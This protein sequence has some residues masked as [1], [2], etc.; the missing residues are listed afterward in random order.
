MRRSHCGLHVMHQFCGCSQRGQRTVVTWVDSFDGETILYYQLDNKSFVAT[1]PHAQS[2]V[3]DRNANLKF[4]ESVPQLVS[5]LCDRIKRL[6]LL[7][8]VTQER[9]A[10]SNTR[11]YTQRKLGQDY[12]V[13]WARGFFPRDVN[14]SWVRN[15][16]VVEMGQET[17]DVVPESDGT[18]QVRSVRPLNEDGG[19]YVCQVEHEAVNGKLFIP[20]ERKREVLNEGLIIIG[21]VLAILGICSA[22]VTTVVYY[23][24]LHGGKKS[25]IHPTGSQGSVT[26]SGGGQWEPG[27]SPR[28]GGTWRLTGDTTNNDQWCRRSSLKGGTWVR[29]TTF[30]NLANGSEETLTGSW[31]DQ[32]DPVICLT[33][34]ATNGVHDRPSLPRL[35]D[36]TCDP[37]P[38]NGDEES[39]TGSSVDQWRG[40]PSLAPP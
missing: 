6:V 19:K 37:D 24:L 30:L 27:I 31:G 5:S 22:I 29:G 2:L 12:L 16:E 36:G 34:A 9:R 39:V 26:G 33:G 23:W 18:Y 20:L 4:V 7:T 1:Q 32:W 15:G 13:C 8:N 28:G 17:V 14:V 35:R 38:A 3:D 11:A 21:A 25:G 10:P 40:G